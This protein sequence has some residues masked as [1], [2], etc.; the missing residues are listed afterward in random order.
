MLELTKTPRTD[1]LVAFSLEVPAEYAAK[2]EVALNSVLALVQDLDD[3]ETVSV[4]EALP[5]MTPGKILRGARGVHEMTQ[6]QLAAAA[7]I[8]VANLSA[9]ENDRRPIG[10]AMAKRLAKALGAPSYKI[11]L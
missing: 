2:V 8:S 10:K 3:L 5:D 1:G 7:G 11:F 9:M 4:E 6:K